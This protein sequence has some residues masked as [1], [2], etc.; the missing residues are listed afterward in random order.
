MTTKIYKD[1]D[2]VGLE[3]AMKLAYTFGQESAANMGPRNPTTDDREDIARGYGCGWDQ[4][5]ADH[6]TA[7][8]HEFWRGHDTVTNVPYCT[9]RFVSYDHWQSDMYQADVCMV[10][11]AW[12][13]HRT[14]GGRLLGEV[15][16]RP[17][18]AINA[19]MEIAQ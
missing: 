17:H 15:F 4:I 7:L 14:D 8:R 2:P 1:G 5:S 11:S 6:R 19:F 16:D 10:D 12:T 3:K 18:D 9:F 13:V